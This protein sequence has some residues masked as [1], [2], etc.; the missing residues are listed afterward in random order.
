L[1]TRT[2]LGEQFRSFS[3][4]L[5]S[6]QHLP[7]TLSLLGPNTVLNT[8]I[9]NTLILRS[10]LN[11]RDNHKKTTGK[12]IILYILIFK[13]CIAYWKTQDSVPNHIKPKAYSTVKAS[14]LLQKFGFLKNGEF[15]R[16]MSSYFLFASLDAYVVTDLQ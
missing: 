11:M 6:F 10:S 4:S 2:I 3:S 1:V 5:C 14:N 15:F 16:R 9:S 12:Y 8:L 13:F 7:V